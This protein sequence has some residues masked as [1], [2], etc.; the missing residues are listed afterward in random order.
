MKDYRNKVYDII[1]EDDENKLLGTL[2]DSIIITFILI[3]IIF[4]ILDTFPFPGWYQSL[5]KIVELVAVVLFTV[6]YLLRIWTAPLAYPQKKPFIAR[7]KYILSPM[8]LI[9][10]VSILP[11]YFP[12]FLPAGFVALRALRIIRL[13]RIFKIS[14]YNNALSVIGRVFRHKAHQLL[15]SMLI[16]FML[17][18]IASMVMYDMEN[19]AQPD[20]FDNAF[21]AFWWAI[22]TVTTVG[23]GDL[24]PITTAGK[25]IG[26]IIAFL[27]IGL[28]AIPT[29]II[30]AGFVEESRRM[31]QEQDSASSQASG[32]PK[33]YCPYCG[34]KLDDA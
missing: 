34:N 31:E 4:I 27:G 30:S 6:E 12:L 5:S 26:G 17:M 10:L 32:T 3:N 33:A 2:F 13:L 8:A 21:S 7:G 18:L 16:V 24:Y 20:K 25:M 11:F 9:D 23:Y 19:S 15:S 1:R 22:A 28:V 29:G 14:R